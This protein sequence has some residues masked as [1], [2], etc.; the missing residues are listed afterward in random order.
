M[1]INYAFFKN[2]KGEIEYNKKCQK[3]VKDCKQSWRVKIISC[4][5][6]K[7]KDKGNV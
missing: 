2:S 6:R 1:P 4:K 3:C 7:A 5:Y